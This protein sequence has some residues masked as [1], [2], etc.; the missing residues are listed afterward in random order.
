MKNHNGLIMVSLQNYLFGRPIR[1]HN[2]SSEMNSWGLSG[3]SD[4]SK[5]WL[6]SSNS[7]ETHNGLTIKM[8]NSTKS[9][10]SYTGVD[11]GVESATTGMTTVCDSD[12]TLPGTGYIGFDFTNNF[13]W[14]G[15]SNIISICYDNSGTSL[16][17][18]SILV[19]I[20]V[21]R[22]NYRRWN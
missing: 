15:T 17:T 1:V 4:I 19:S 9:S 18:S 8:K 7:G 3:S 20:E 21:E 6:C 2:L 13:I 16:N 5:L 11:G 14:D 10:Y 12:Y 22:A